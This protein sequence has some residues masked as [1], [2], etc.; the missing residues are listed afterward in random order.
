MGVPTHVMECTS[1]SAL[2]MGSSAGWLQF[3]GPLNMLGKK[4]N[5]FIRFFQL[6][7]GVC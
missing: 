5:W 2:A 7:D 6:P 4:G 1:G 3:L